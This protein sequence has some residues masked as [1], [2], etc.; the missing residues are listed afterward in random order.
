MSE[1]DP[2][3][4]TNF[5]DWFLVTGILKQHGL[6]DVWSQWSQQASNYNQAKNEQIWSSSTGILDIN[7][8][9]WVVRKVGSDRDF[10]ATWKPYHPVNQ[11]LTN[12]QQIIFNKLFV[13]QGLSREPNYETIVI[14]SCTGTGKTTAIAQHMETRQTKTPHF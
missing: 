13:S 9:V 2:K 12:V 8:L 7:Y 10:V 14:K 3:F 5:S 4:L 11:D 1:L 6:K